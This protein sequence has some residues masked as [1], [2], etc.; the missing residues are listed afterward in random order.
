MRPRRMR[1][2]FA[3]AVPTETSMEPYYAEEQGF[4]KAA[5]L[6]VQLQVLPNGAQVAALVASG[7]ADIGFANLIPLAQGY[8]RGIPFVF[9]FP[10]ALYS[11]RA[12]SAVLMVEKTSSIRS[13]RDLNGKTIGVPNLG[14]MTQLGALAWID[15][16]GGDSKSVRWIELTLAALG[17][18]L[19][20]QRV[21]AIVCGEP[22]CE[23]VKTH[24][25]G[26]TNPLDS[27]ARSFV[28]GA[29]FGMKP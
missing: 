20:A 26:L 13:A 7:G 24:A 29:W 9:V 11:S 25:R 12:P 1:G 22:F 21:D 15:R 28:S 16:N 10:A 18:A 27:I 6:T 5:G 4:F 3:A 14:N 2:F 19:E 17:P 23:P 8:L